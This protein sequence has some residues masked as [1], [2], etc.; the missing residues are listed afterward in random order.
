[1]TPSTGP[2][3]E[4]LHR[5]VVAMVDGF[6]GV[7]PPYPRLPESLVAAD[8]AHGV[9]LNVDLF[10]R[11]LRTGIEPD[12]DD[13]ADMVRLAVERVRDG[14]AVTDVLDRYRLGASFVWDRLLDSAT[15]SDRELL[16]TAA[17][18]LM[19]YLGLLTQ[20]IVAAATD[21]A[22]DPRYELMEHRRA[23]TDALLTGRDPQ[24]WPGRAPV[25]LAERYL[26]TVFRLGPDIG[27]AAADLR[28]RVESLPGVLVRMDIS[29]WVAL[30]PLPPGDDGRDTTA[31]LRT[32]L[33][34]TAP[35]YWVGTATAPRPDIPS[36]YA[37]ARI[38]AEL[39]RCLERAEN[40]CRRADLQFEYTVA[41]GDA[42]RPGLAAVLAPLE[43]RPVLART[44]EL[45]LATGLNQLATARRLDIHRNTVNYRLC[46]IRD[47]IGVDPQN[48]TEA[49]TV[50][51][52]LTA[53]R[54]QAH[55]F[56]P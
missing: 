29:G 7:V 23:V 16:L 28:H 22:H 14:A 37:E 21:R 39:G 51:A 8:F 43:T 55:H 12:E 50:A 11:Y 52:A 24:H 3:I 47:L 36:G 34:R 25:R 13:T 41:A 1:M 45:F 27:D 6:Y 49:M 20:R 26:I 4:E 10:F 17:A 35:A 48:P 40:I 56:A 42:A 31:R 9:K 38:L 2:G 18:P 19:R 33:P 54:L 15:A 5:S 30:I 53:Q 32:R 44:L 46:R